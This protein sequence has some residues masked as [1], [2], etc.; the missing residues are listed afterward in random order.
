MK[1]FADEMAK[2]YS[3]EYIHCSS[4][5][6]SLDGILIPELKILIV[7]GT[8]PHTIGPVIQEQLMKLLISAFLNVQSLNKHKTA[9]IQTNKAKSN[10]Y[11][12]AYRYLKAAGIIYNEISSI[13]D[14]YVDVEK[15]NEMCEKAITGLFAHS[16]DKKRQCQK[17]VYRIFYVKRIY[18]LYRKVL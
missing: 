12:S 7:D 15:F 5:N 11:L 17:I 4:D 3:I 13:Y 2:N 6:A 14:L 18:K 1:K 10:K 9:I 8:S 16:S